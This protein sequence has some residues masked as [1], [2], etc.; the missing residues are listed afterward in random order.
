MIGKRILGVLFLLIGLSGLALS[1]VG[2]IIGRQVIEEVGTGVDQALILTNDTLDTVGQTLLVTK[3]VMSKIDGGIET[4]GSTA[5]NLSKT[6]SETRPML[7][8]IAQVISEDVPEGIES[9]QTALPDVAE[10]AGAIDDAL[11]VLDSFQVERQI[12][13]VPISFDLG[14]DYN[15][16]NP[17]DETVLQLGESLE[18][19]PN[20]LRNLQLHIDV[21]NDNLATI[22]QNVESIAADLT[23]ISESTG[24][25]EP[26]I[27]E[28]IRIVTET[29]D[30][31]RQARSSIGDQLELAELILTLLFVW[32]G[33]NQAIPLYLS[34]NMLTTR[35]K[36]SDKRA[37][38]QG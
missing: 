6:L 29:G 31:V 8:Q 7:G 34:W 26:L 3:D 12:F 33:L 28:Y 27:D 13:G 25:I 22:G 14:V 17:L 30:L 5:I 24:E 9:M 1:V 16:E 23:L 10:A 20:N 11:R 38:K 37:A 36:P 21:A 2:V 32:I 4:A 19:L 18:G 15:P 35:S